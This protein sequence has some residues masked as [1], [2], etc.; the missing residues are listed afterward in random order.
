MGNI[1][2]R[3]TAVRGIQRDEP[4]GLVDPSSKCRSRPSTQLYMLT[5]A[6]MPRPSVSTATSV[7]AGLMAYGPM[8]CYR[9]YAI[10]HQP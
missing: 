8:N 5:F 7:K 4:I 9:P 3:A 6:P 10:S 1:S 2:I